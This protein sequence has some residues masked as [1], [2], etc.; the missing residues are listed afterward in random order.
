M[1]VEKA[2][3]WETA[4]LHAGARHRACAAYRDDSYPERRCDY[5]DKPYRGPAVYCRLDC[6]LADAGTPTAQVDA[7]ER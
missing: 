4:E 6:A 1:T 5:C 2:D 3:P 7:L